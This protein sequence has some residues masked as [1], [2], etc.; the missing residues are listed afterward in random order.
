[1]K[2][3]NMSPATL[4]HYDGR[5]FLRTAEE[6]DDNYVLAGWDSTRIRCVDLAS[7]DIRCFM[8]GLEVEESRFKFNYITRASIDEDCQIG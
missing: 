3:D 7:G 2:L 8:K 1:M 6:V 4:F 5:E